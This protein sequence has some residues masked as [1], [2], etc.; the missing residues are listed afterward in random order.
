MCC[1]LPC[2][3]T[4]QRRGRTQAYALYGRGRLCVAAGLPV[5]MRRA[6]RE[7]PLPSVGAYPY[8]VHRRWADEAGH[9][10]RLGSG[11]ERSKPEEERQEGRVEE[12]HQ[13]RARFGWTTTNKEALVA[14]PMVRSEL[15]WCQPP[16]P[17]L[18]AWVLAVAETDRSDETATADARTTTTAA[19]AP[20][21]KD[22][23]ASSPRRS[24]TW[25][26]ATPAPRSPS[27]DEAPH[28]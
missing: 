2:P 28:G 22:N 19:S 26:R 18:D 17:G 23:C 25:A 7:T 13:C 3:R 27:Q 6:R 9:L 1:C 8:L 5:V 20:E 15:V 12:G 14:R 16:L 21:G 10:G 4:W 24:G 11:R